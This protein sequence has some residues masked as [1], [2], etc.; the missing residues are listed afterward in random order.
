MIR[1]EISAH[2]VCAGIPVVMA[3]NILAS[4]LR[5]LGDGGTPLYAMI[6]AAVINVALDLCLYWAFTG[7]SGCGGSDGNRTAVFRNFL[8][9]CHQPGGGAGFTRRTSKW[10]GLSACT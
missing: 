2:H 3:Y 6:V 7:D 5:A 9:S 8:P 1:F 10:K 4:I